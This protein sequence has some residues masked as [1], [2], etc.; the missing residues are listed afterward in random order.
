MQFKVSKGQ[1][2]SI[3]SQGLTLMHQTIKKVSDDIESMGFNTAVSTLMIYA[4]ALD[5]E[6]KITQKEFE[7]LILLLAP[8]APHIAEELWSL[9][10][11]TGSIHTQEWPKYDSK[12]VLGDEVTLAIQVNGKLRGSLTVPRDSSE[13]TVKSQ[14]LAMP[15]VKKW[16][17]GREP[18]KVIF[19]PGKI[20]SVVT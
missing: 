8:F 19:V 15:E 5:K 2:L 14:V 18:K 13:K 7:T 16:L 12:L 4:N 17:L 9:L 3:G 11:H 10:G 1:T 20:V 6:D